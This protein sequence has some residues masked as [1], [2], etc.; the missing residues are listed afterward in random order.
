MKRIILAIICL[1]V[2]IMASCGGSSGNVVV[3]TRPPSAVSDAPA[4]T[5]TQEQTASPTQS[6]APVDTQSAQP[7]PTLADGPKMYTSYAKM[8]SFDTATG[9]ADFDYFD[10]LRG[11][12]A[13]NWLVEQEGYSQSDAEALVNDFADSEYIEKNSNSQLRTIDL[14]KVPV[15]LII[16]DDGTYTDDI[17]PRLVDADTLKAIYADKPSTLLKTFFY[18]VKVSDSGAVE[19]V[20]Q[21]Y[22]P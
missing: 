20:N 6:A 19:S 17:E 7:S 11:E 5:E 16:N 3:V 15:Y 13:V 18:E 10:M 14:S 21:V 22:W 1:T 9:M 8:V 4:S 2:L 12:D